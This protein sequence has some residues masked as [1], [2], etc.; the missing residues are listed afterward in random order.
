MA[1][2]NAAMTSEMRVPINAIRKTDAVKY[3][4]GGRGKG[5]GIDD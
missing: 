4:G 5:G 2:R 3:R 1:V